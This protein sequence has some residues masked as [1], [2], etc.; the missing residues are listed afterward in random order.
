MLCCVLGSRYP[1]E[2][3]PVHREQCGGVRLRTSH[4]CCLDISF[5]SVRM[6]TF[7]ALFFLMSLA[8]QIRA[9][10]PELRHKCQCVLVQ[11]V[12][13]FICALS[14]HRVFPFLWRPLS[15]FGPN[16][17]YLQHH[18]NQQERMFLWMGQPLTSVDSSFLPYTILM[19]YQWTFHENKGN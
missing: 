12:V 15:C 17:W 13:L 14:E 5:A 16:V 6:F 9:Q 18:L 7:F 2:S 19:K 11:A 4:L 8:F 10:S 3:W 1:S